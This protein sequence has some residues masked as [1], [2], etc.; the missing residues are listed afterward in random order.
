MTFKELKSSISKREKSYLW[1]FIILLIVLTTFPYMFGWLTAPDAYNYTGAHRFAAADFS[2]YYSYIEQAKQGS[3]LFKDLFTTEADQNNFFSPIWLLG[4]WVSKVG[5]SS[6]FIL[7]LFRIVSIILL[8][9]SLYWLIA[10][11]IK[12]KLKR[13]ATSLIMFFGSGFGVYT[14][15]I[16]GKS[17]LGC[18][19]NYPLEFWVSEYN[20]FLSAYHAPHFILSLALIALIFL[21]A[22]LAWDSNKI[23]YSIVSGILFFILMIIHSYHLPTIIAVL[24]FWMIYLILINKKIWLYFKHYIIICI[25]AILPFLYLIWLYFTDEVFK[26][27]GQTMLNVM[28]DWHISLLSYGAVLAF[29]IVS[30]FFFKKNYKKYEEKYGL[31]ILWAVVQFMLIFLPIINYRRRLVEGLFIPLSILAVIGM[32]N[33]YVR[34]KNKFI[35]KIFKNKFILAVLFFI[36]IFASNIYVVGI[37]IVYF[38]LNLPHF[39]Y[40]DNLKESFTWIKD[41]IKNDE[42][43]LSTYNVGNFI[44]A[45]TGRTT[46]VGHG[47]ETLGFEIKKDLTK[48]FFIKDQA[49]NEKVNFLIN[50]DIDYVLYSDHQK[51]I[52]SE[53]D[54]QPVFLDNQEYFEQVFESGDVKIFK[55]KK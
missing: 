43:I 23:K 21:F 34:I 5:F 25:F 40:S 14:F 13:L 10:Y 33:L 54:S 20:I 31:L 15:F 1:V 27:K 24:F 9:F 44:P 2:V 28:P 18:L 45:Y 55:F 53:L 16:L 30:V 35:L 46:Y 8:G 37:D 39:Y 49:I 29:A 26:E 6:A 11:F 32:F 4:G 12:N 42:V 41:N 38:A 7:H 52:N 51:I 36:F 22:L 17:G 50:S 48:D 3:F 19:F 47:D